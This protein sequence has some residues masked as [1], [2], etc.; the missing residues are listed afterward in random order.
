MRH[1]AGRVRDDERVAGIG[2]GLA[3]IEGRRPSHRQAGQIGDRAAHVPGHRHQQGADG[4]RL[5]AHHEYGP[6]CDLQFAEH[7]AELRLAVGQTLI[8]GLL[9]GWGDG[10]GGP[11]A[12]RTRGR[13][14]V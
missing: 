4:G 5:V 14:R 12:R 3:G 13:I 11:Q 1:D 6:V 8:E 7:F 9:P 10:G 2:L